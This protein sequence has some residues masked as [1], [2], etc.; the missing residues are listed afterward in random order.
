MSPSLFDNIK[1]TY[2][3]PADYSEPYFTYLNRS[4]RKYKAEARTLLDSWFKKYAQ[5]HKKSI[6]DLKKRFRSKK[7]EHHLGA[8]TELYVNN[9]LLENDYIVKSHPQLPK[10]SAHP[11]FLAI[12][13]DDK[14]KG[15]LIEAVVVYAKLEDKRLKKFTASIFDII[16]QINSPDFFII[17]TFE[18]VDYYNQPKIGKIKKFIEKELSNL[19]YNAVCE[20]YEKN[21]KLPE[22]SWRQDNWRIKFLAS[23][24][25]EKGRRIRDKNSRVLGAMSEGVRYINTDEFIKK[26]VLEKAT[27]YGKHK[28]PF[29][30]AINIVADDGFCD[31]ETIMD[32]L[33]GK[34]MIRFRNYTDGTQKR[35]N[36]RT[37]DGIWI[38]PKRGIVYKRMSGLLVIPGLTSS[39][40]QKAKPILWHHPEADNKFSINDLNVTH[41]VYNPKTE[42]MEKIKL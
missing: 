1:R 42:K 34:E 11:E 4:N 18:S 2:K 9:L 8:L 13:K 21:K 17:A 6:K 16:D 40:I 22:W 15:F 23:P 19:N 41:R 3:G 7:N 25:S 20:Q 14:K 37:M 35:Q 10:I 26:R 38:N 30:V 39:T 29:L 33:F 28:M 27:K 5:I 36:T 32:A 12:R 24:V 31:D